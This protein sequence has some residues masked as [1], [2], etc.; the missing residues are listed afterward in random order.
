MEN[1]WAAVGRLGAAFLDAGGEAGGFFSSVKPLMA[2][3]IEYFDGLGDVAADLG[4]KFGEAFNS[5][6]EKIRSVKQWYDDLSP[7]M[8]SLTQKVALFGSIGAVS[9]GPFLL[10]IGKVIVGVGNLITRIG[11]IAGAVT[12]L[13]GVFGI[14]TGPIGITIGIITALIAAGVLLYKNW[15]TIKT[16]AESIFPSIEPSINILKE[17][18]TTL[19]SHVDP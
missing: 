1:V 6:I 11:V 14:L 8:Q 15:E 17:A 16:K 18:F 2:D 7:A 5:I 13:G 4:V 9:I 10:I 12:K 3:L 19:L